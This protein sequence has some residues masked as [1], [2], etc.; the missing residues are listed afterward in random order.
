MKIGTVCKDWLL[1]SVTP[2]L[3]LGAMCFPDYASIGIGTICSPLFYRALL[4]LELEAANH[5][6]GEAVRGIETP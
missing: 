1:S 6:P 5:Q 4:H 2:S 3:A